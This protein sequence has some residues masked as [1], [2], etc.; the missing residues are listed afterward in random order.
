LAAVELR[1]DD[2]VAAL[3]RKLEALEASQAGSTQELRVLRSAQALQAAKVERCSSES[4]ALKEATG[5]HA[6]ELAS[7]KMAASDQR[8]ELDAATSQEATLAERVASMD[9]LFSRFFQDSRISDVNKLRECVVKDLSV[10]AARPAQDL[11]AA[12]AMRLE[13]L[14]NAV[15][16][17]TTRLDELGCRHTAAF[18]ALQGHNAKHLMAYTQELRSV[19]KVMTERVSQAE[20]DLTVIF[21]KQDKDAESTKEALKK[22]RGRLEE[23]GTA[24]GETRESLAGESRRRDAQSVELAER[25]DKQ[26]VKHEALESSLTKVG[27]QL[28]ALKQQ[29]AG[30]ERRSGDAERQLEGQLRE[31]GRRLDACEEVQ[32]RLGQGEASLQEDVEHL[33]VSLGEVAKA[34]VKPIQELTVAQGRH[35]QELQSIKDAFAKHRHASTQDQEEGG[36][37]VGLAPNSREEEEEPAELAATGLSRREGALLL[38]TAGAFKRLGK[39]GEECRERRRAAAETGPRARGIIAAFNAVAGSAAEAAPLSPE[40]CSGSRLQWLASPRGQHWQK[41]G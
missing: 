28:D 20:S 34:Q 7:F 25:L 8:R 32:A 30:C 31:A 35:A 5:I 16:S 13:H 38:N 27:V 26:A 18:E 15:S 19:K 41:G 3:A 23:L 24:L 1:H 40:A 36:A 11:V 12:Q 2:S 10:V 37:V 29:L 6:E 21:D 17:L 14:E 4:L 9:K 33:K 39:L 22:M